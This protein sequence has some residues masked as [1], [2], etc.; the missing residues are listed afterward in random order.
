MARRTVAQP[1]PNKTEFGVTPKLADVRA[2][3]GL[4]VAVT[5]KRRTDE[6]LGEKWAGCPFQAAQGRMPCKAGPVKTAR[7]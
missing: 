3:G 6:P 4:S 2:P 7:M 1:F 5:S